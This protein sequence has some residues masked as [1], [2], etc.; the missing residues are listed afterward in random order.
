MTNPTTDLAARFEAKR[1][2]CER[3]PADKAH[4]L[5][6]ALHHAI[7]GDPSM[8]KRVL[9]ELSAPEARDMAR[10]DAAAPVTGT[11]GTGRDFE[12][13]LARIIHRHGKGLD[14]TD[15]IAG[16]R[17]LLA[18]KGSLSPLREETTAPQ[19]AGAER[20]DLAE[21]ERLSEAATP[22]GAK[23]EIASFRC[24]HECDDVD[25]PGSLSI[26]SVEIAQI[27]E[28]Y[29][30]GAT[31]FYEADGAFIAA[32]WNAYRAGHLVPASLATARDGGTGAGDPRKEALAVLEEIPRWAT[33]E[34]FARAF[35]YLGRPAEA[36]RI[37]AVLATLSATD[38]AGEARDA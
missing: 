7:E 12:L 33:P 1:E 8:L 16:A 34:E 24:G 21:L 20:V 22:G 11:A 18:R 17:D 32:L 2:E 15:T 35:R 37:E 13:M 26:G 27:H 30:G 29:G 28:R 23:F 10:A 38:Q 31:P 25:L 9:G 36:D 14:I 3:I 19:P 4:V 5:A 6:V